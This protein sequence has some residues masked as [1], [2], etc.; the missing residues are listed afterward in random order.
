MQEEVDVEEDGEDQRSRR[1]TAENL[2]MRTRAATGHGPPAQLQNHCA[3][4]EPPSSSYK[5]S[6]SNHRQ[7]SYIVFNLTDDSDA[8]SRRRKPTYKTVATRTLYWLL[9]GCGDDLKDGT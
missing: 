7:S 3:G 5:T 9:P 8:W 2:E 4:A 6:N 1:M